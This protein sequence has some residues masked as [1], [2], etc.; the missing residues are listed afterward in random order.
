[1][2]V[3][4]SLALRLLEPA[5]GRL[6]WEGDAKVEHNVEVLAFTW[7]TGWEQVVRGSF[8]ELVEAVARN[9]EELKSE[10]EPVTFRVRVPS[11]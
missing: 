7:P 8:R 6:L 2:R 1:V 10:L 5:S 11:Q 4:F 9:N 3:S